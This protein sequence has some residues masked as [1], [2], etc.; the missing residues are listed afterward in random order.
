MKVLIT[1]G[2]GYIGSLLVPLLLEKGHSV[3]VVDNL[4]FNQTTLLL[5]FSN[6]IFSFT[7]G[8]IRD[9]KVLKPLVDE[10]DCIVHLAGIVGEPACRVNPQLATTVN[11]DASKLLNRLRGKKPL[12][13]SSTGSNYGKVNGV[14]TEETVTNPLSLYAKTKLDAEKDFLDKGDVV[15]YRFATGFGVSPRMRLD[16]LVNDFCHK[17]VTSGSLIVYQKDVR[18][19][20]IHVRDMARALLFA[21]ENFSTLKNNIFNV[22]HE[23]LNHTKEEMVKEIQRQYPRFYVH[24]ADVGE[25]PDKRDYAVSYAKIRARGFETEYALS[26]GVDELLRALPS[27][28]IPNPYSN[29][30]G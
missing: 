14:C 24:F 4:L 27:V 20:F 11:S 23:S 2:A 21:V 9:E 3:R 28:T 10:A 29:F 30:S 16:L 18:R 5:Y 25:D 17:A 13:F 7:Y 15:V 8:D 1:G 19:T 6:K 12:I 26:Q 22:G